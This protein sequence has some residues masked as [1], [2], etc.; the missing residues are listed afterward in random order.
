MKAQSIDVTTAAQRLLAQDNILIL[1]HRRPDGDTLGSAFA[2][3]FA[4]QRLGK[5]AR[6][7]CADP[8]P[9][10]YSYFF[11]T[12]EYLPE[13]FE[14]DYVVA[15][16]TATTPLLGDL[17]KTYGETVDLAIDHHKSNSFFAKETL[18][19]TQAPAAAQ[20]VCQVIGAMGVSLDAQIANPLYTGIVTDT[21]CF[22]YASVTPETMRTGALLM[23]N[24][25]DHGM[26]NRLMFE[27]NTPGRLAVDKLVLESIQ[28]YFDG[29]CATIFIAKDWK[30]TYGITDDD[31][32]GIATLPRTIE[33]VLAGVTLREQGG[34]SFRISLRT[35]DPVDASKICEMF[36]GGGHANAAGCTIQGTEEQVK[37]KI[38]RAVGLEL[39]RNNLWK[40]SC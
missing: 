3:L 19:N 39:E 38:T 27:T 12:G 6:V 35:T 26:I 22:R 28:Y 17:A 24:G 15:V 5:T 1:A 25:A 36:G 10:K 21:G 40:E 33:G 4:L 14:E 37:E 2:L 11:S 8:I 23:E 7:E 29:L 34:N 31:L 16:D 30:N 18:L 20:V 32:S 13:V 9:E